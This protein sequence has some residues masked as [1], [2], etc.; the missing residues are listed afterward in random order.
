MRPRFI[1]R[2]CLFPLCVLGARAE[3][4]HTAAGARG[5]AIDHPNASANAT[6]SA[7]H[8]LLAGAVADDANEPV[9]VRDELAVPAIRPIRD[10]TSSL[11]LATTALAGIGAFGCLRSARRIQWAPTGAAVDRAAPLGGFEL[12]GG[13]LPAPTL[14]LIAPLPVTRRRLAARAARLRP[15]DTGPLWRS[16]RAPP[17]NPR[18]R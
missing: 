13:P 4:A 18:K 3:F 2:L 1:L 12:D 17:C 14:A 6:G 15:S 10:E 16:P 5:L 11:A 7:L 8:W 9:E